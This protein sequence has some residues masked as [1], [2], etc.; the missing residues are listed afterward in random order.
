MQLKH[1]F[2]SKRIIEKCKGTH[3]SYEIETLDGM[4]PQ[5]QNHSFGKTTWHVANREVLL[6]LLR[7]KEKTAHA[8]AHCNPIPNHKMLRGYRPLFYV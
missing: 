2:I 3:E 7:T 4:E 8:F 1:C 5:R 6:L